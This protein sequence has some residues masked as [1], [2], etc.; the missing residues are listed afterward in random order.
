M[1]IVQTIQIDKNQQAIKPNKLAELYRACHDHQTSDQYKAR[2]L[3]MFFDLKRT[4]SQQV[5]SHIAYNLTVSMRKFILSEIENSY[6]ISST[7][8]SNQR[9][10][11]NVTEESYGK[12]RYVGGYCVAKVRQKY[13]KQLR[14]NCYKLKCENQVKYK[15]SCLM[16]EILDNMS[17]NE[18]IVSLSQ[19]PQSRRNISDQLFE[20]F[21]S[22]CKMCLNLLVCNNVNFHCENLFQFC[23]SVIGKNCQLFE[24]FVQCGCTK[25]MP[26][27]LNKEQV[28]IPMLV[29]E[30]LDT[31][32][33]IEQ[34]YKELTDK[35]LLVMFNQ[36]RK[37]FLLCLCVEKKMAHRKQ[38]LVRSQKKEVTVD[39]A[40]ILDDDSKEKVISHNL[41][42]S[43]ISKNKGYMDCFGKKDLVLLCKAYNCQIKSRNLKHEIVV[44]LNSV[45]GS[46]ESIPLAELLNKSKDL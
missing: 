5:M 6:K 8:V 16:L 23:S 41:L 29:A 32:G 46:D 31:V 19:F 35:F 44:K 4:I 10:Q 38:I 45:I 13:T 2:V 12:I 28:L 9:V 14:S 40:F 7:T 15:E 21:V 25:S 11:R 18:S 20:L 1:D 17:V 24:E 42:K 39:M 30:M 27:D 26:E 43:I 37:D 34:L 22:T 33:A 36:F 3:L